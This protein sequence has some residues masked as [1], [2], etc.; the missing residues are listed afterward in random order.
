[1]GP[2]AGSVPA[3]ASM[4][5]LACG[6]GGC[7]RRPPPG[8]TSVRLSDRQHKRCLGVKPDTPATPSRGPAGGAA[9][10]HPGTGALTHCLC[11]GSTQ[12]QE[13]PVLWKELIDE[14]RI[15]DHEVAYIDRQQGLHCAGC[16]SNWRSMALG[17]AVMACYG[18]PAL[19]SGFVRSD[20][21]RKLRVLE[22]NE[23]GGLTPFFTELPNHML[24]RYPEV[25]MMNL[26]LEDRAF[27]LVVHSDT[28]EHV[29]H[30]VR[31]L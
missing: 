27:D 6:P 9:M 26:P 30:P 28:L 7:R 10:D 20:V 18:Y 2:S 11:C 15:A 29:P 23:A 31:G 22:I 8:A 5:T 4:Q 25:D 13:H 1:K 19:F 24:V 14:W 3:D 17:E 21:G 12:L 16:R